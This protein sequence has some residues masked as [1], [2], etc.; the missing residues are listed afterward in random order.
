MV[1]AQ[2]VPHRGRV[3][4]MP[5]IPQSS[6]DPSLAPG[7]ILFR[8]TDHELFNLLRDAIASKLAAVLTAVKLLRDQ[9]L[10]GSP[11]LLG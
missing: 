4:G 2:D 3:D 11:G 1:A 10:F 6:L 9:A 5:Q 8:H 7:G